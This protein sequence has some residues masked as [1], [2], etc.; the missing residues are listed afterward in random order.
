MSRTGLEINIGNAG[1]F[2]YISDIISL[3]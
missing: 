2:F 1:N 3:P